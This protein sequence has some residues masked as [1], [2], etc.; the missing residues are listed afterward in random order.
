MNKKKINKIAIFTRAPES[1]GYQLVKI[2]FNAQGFTLIEL[3]VS[4][5]ILVILVSSV[6]AILTSGSRLWAVSVAQIDI[7]AS[8]R[9]AMA[10]VFDDLSQA[11][12][13][14]VIVSPGHDAITFQTPDSYSGGIISWGNQ[15][16][17]SLGGLNG[18]QLLRTDLVSGDVQVWGNNITL[19]QLDQT[20]DDT[21]DIQITLS[22]QSAKGDILTVQLGSQV[23]LRNK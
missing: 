5:S 12:Q 13:D 19:L 1:R 21:I 16:Q 15:I 10:R 7:S 4:C 22:K 9:N 20:K 2:W 3:M 17:Y 6:F 18:Q 14:T 23:R 8:A 11:G